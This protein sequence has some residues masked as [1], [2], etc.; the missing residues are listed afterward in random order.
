MNIQ[1]HLIPEP[2]YVNLDSDSVHKYVIDIHKVDENPYY[3]EFGDKP[4]HWEMTIQPMA[5]W[6]EDGVVDEFGNV[7]D[8]Y[9]F[10][11]TSYSLAPTIEQFSKH[12]Y[13]ECWATLRA[14]DI[15]IKYLSD[16]TKLSVNWE[17]IQ[18][19]HVY[20]FMKE[21]HKNYTKTEDFL[22]DYDVFVNRIYNNFKFIY[23]M[24]CGQRGMFLKSFDLPIGRHFFDFLGIKIYTANLK[25]VDY[26]EYYNPTHWDANARKKVIIVKYCDVG[27]GK[28]YHTV[29]DEGGNEYLQFYSYIKA[30]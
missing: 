10:K 17:E 19:Q 22:R 11:M 30:L 28:F 29:Q 23:G 1:N 26:P 18:P 25:E 3:I 16:D 24:V 14:L 4:T 9:Q 27:K 7:C 20:K 12:I 8:P 5:A 13:D 21:I 15:D 6:V 2:E